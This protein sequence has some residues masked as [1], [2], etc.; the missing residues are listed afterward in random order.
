MRPAAV[1]TSLISAQDG[2]STPCRHTTWHHQQLYSR[3]VTSS[4]LQRSHPGNMILI[5]A[6]IKSNCYITMN[7]AASKHTDAHKLHNVRDK[8]SGV[9]LGLVPLPKLWSL[10]SDFG[11]FMDAK[12]NLLIIYHSE[13]LHKTWTTVSCIW[14]TR[15][16]K[17]PDHVRQQNMCHQYASCHQP[18]VCYRRQLMN[19]SFL[20]LF[21]LLW[22]FPV[23]K[24]PHERTTRLDYCCLTGSW[25]FR[26][27][28]R[29]KTDEMSFFPR[30]KTLTINCP[31]WIFMMRENHEYIHINGFVYMHTFQLLF[32]TWQYS[33]FDTGCV[34]F[35][36][37]V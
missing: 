13:Y 12:N 1:R 33:E 21:K 30:S 37:R 16:A 14:V 17:E 24:M 11:A 22:T 4:T 2:L 27:L 34:I 3:H 32:W 23:G 15:R 6:S 18:N 25:Y 19:Q 29:K 10:S 28:D 5:Q 36:I 35:L 20:W 9:L 31:W 8:E 26:F 7:S